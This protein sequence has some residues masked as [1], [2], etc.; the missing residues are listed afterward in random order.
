[1]SVETPQVEES[2]PVVT[3]PVESTTVP[4]EV[5]APIPSEP[6]TEKPTTEAPT[7]VQET[8]TTAEPAKDE[9]VVEATP[10]TE[11]VLGYKAPGLLK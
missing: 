3:K 10:A 11:G 4:S 7:T 1:M 8:Q 6:A 2:T 5:S 9:T